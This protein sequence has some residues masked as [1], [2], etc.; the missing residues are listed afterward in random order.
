MTSS[1][2]RWVVLTAGTFA[3]TSYSAIW[4]G[5]AVMAP[6]LRTDLHLSLGRTGL[7][8]SASLAG[9]VLS[10]IPWGLAT[11]RF[12]ERRVLV[13]GLGLCGAALIGASQVHGFAALA[14]L[15]AAAGLTGASVQ[16]AS[17]RAVMHWFPSSQRGVA[18]AI[19]QTAIPLSGFAVSLAIPPVEH[20]GGVGWGFAALGLACLAGAAVGL[21]IREGPSRMP[22][23]EEAVDVRP[24]RDR[25][26]WTLSIGSALVIAPQLC[27]TGFAVVF[28][29]DHRSLSAASAA[30]VLAVMQVG[31]I[32]GRIAAGRWSDVRGSR[33]MPLRTIAIVAAAL[34]ALLGILV[35][36]PLLALLPVLVIGGVLSMSWNSLSF[37]AAVELVG[38]GRSG[39]AI[40][41]QQ[42]ILNL[43]GVLYP[44]VFGALVAVS[45]WRIGFVT[46]ALF[47]L[48]GWYVLGALDR[49]QPV[50]L[51]RPRPHAEVGVD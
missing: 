2:Y 48:A 49:P 4:L 32:A 36:A 17:G 9:S 19:R 46:V 21:L 28:L 18:L 24:L 43:P 35:D 27:V 37:A 39:S 47:P 34:V 42:T 6:A 22:A 16:S 23:P 15:L 30:R 38:A 10:L 11:D 45:S 20:A 14:V 12:G 41:V 13:V 7:L 44:A 26:L 25:R 31:A 33:I 29:H 8:L 50:G 40:G 5:V 51:R 1:R 3:Q